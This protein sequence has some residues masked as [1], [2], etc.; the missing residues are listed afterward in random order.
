MW[1]KNSLQLDVRLI[2]DA[3]LDHTQN[4]LV[5]VISQLASEEIR[6]ESGL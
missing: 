2:D 4:A 6:V 3:R 1:D 5:R